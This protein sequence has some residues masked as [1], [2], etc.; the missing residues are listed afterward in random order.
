MSGWH[1]D[2]VSFG[3]QSFTAVTSRLNRLNTTFQISVFFSTSTWR[4]HMISKAWRLVA[5][6][7][8]ISMSST[9]ALSC[10]NSLNFGLEHIPIKACFESL[11]TSHMM[12]AFQRELMYCKADH[13]NEIKPNTFNARS[14]YRY[15]NGS[16]LRYYFQWMWCELNMN[17][18]RLLHIF[19]PH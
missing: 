5:K 4:K 8:H 9:H 14:L 17:M 18:K 6:R 19:C 12:T 13:R 7:D 15:L 3:Y 10:W 2:M 16:T 1:A 11:R